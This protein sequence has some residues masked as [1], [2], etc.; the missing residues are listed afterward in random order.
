MYDPSV[1]FDLCVFLSSS[2]SVAS[3]GRVWF[4]NL[5]G[6]GIGDGI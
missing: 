4:N 3:E 1:R 5:T 2:G 6:D